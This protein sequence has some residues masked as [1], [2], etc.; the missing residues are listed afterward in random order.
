MAAPEREGE[1]MSCRILLGFTGIAL[2]V[3]LAPSALAE[4]SRTQALVACIELRGEP[5]TRRDLKLRESETFF[6]LRNRILG[7]TRTQALRSE[8]IEVKGA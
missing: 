5:E 8:Q 4:T 2:L 7:L 3:G 6:K 1:G